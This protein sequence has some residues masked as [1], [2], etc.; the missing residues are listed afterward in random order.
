[1]KDEFVPR[2]FKNSLADEREPL[3]RWPAHDYVDR[4]SAEPGLFPN[5]AAGQI[6]HA[7]TQHLG[8]GEIQLVNG[9]VDRVVFNSGNHIE[10]THFEAKRKAPGPSE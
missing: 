6:P 2:I 9:G 5:V 1:V 3:A 10:S 4:C 8:L 7:G